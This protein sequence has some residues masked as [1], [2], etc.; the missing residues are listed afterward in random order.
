M[1]FNKE[2]LCF[3][4]NNVH[5]N[6]SCLKSK[7]SQTQ[8]I[9]VINAQMPLNHV[10][11]LFTVIEVHRTEDGLPAGIYSVLKDHH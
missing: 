11:R 2:G 4:V 9:L 3:P 6:F 8:N 5:A 1:V 10:K 7:S